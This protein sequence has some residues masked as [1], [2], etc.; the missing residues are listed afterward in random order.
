MFISSVNIIGDVKVNKM[1]AL[2]KK[3]KNKPD[4][5]KLSDEDVYKIL[6]S[7]QCNSEHQPNY[8]QTVT[9]SLLDLSTNSF[10]DIKEFVTKWEEAHKNQIETENLQREKVKNEKIR[11]LLKTVN[12]QTSVFCKELIKV[13]EGK[14]ELPYSPQSWANGSTS[15]S[16]YDRLEFRLGDFSFSKSRHDKRIQFFR[17]GIVVILN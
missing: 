12:K 4:Y 15:S 1:K 7:H 9:E 8:I 17:S 13:I 16:D 3:Y 14:S 5:V 10:V 6:S 2:D 11:I